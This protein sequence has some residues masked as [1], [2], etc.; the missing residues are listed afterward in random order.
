MT[1]T[2]PP[3]DPKKKYCG[4]GRGF[5]TWL[6][7]DKL[8][9]IGLNYCCYE[10]DK[11]YREGGTEQ[12]RM[13]ADRNLQECIRRKLL[14]SKWIPNA[15]ACW[16]AHRYF[17]AVRLLG[18]SCFMYR[19]GPY[20]EALERLARKVLRAARAEFTPGPGW[21]IPEHKLAEFPKQERTLLE[22]LLPKEKPDD[23]A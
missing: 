14:E 23:T 22:K 6:V 4:P 19:E 3:Y 15:I 13:E 21:F 11:A 17:R 1:S 8:F 2:F 12:D 5:I 18:S 7:P 9:G 16:V 20:Q 10:H